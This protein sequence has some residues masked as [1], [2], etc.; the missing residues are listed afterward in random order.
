MA[1]RK[2]GAMDA[3]AKMPWPVG[4][5]AGILAYGAVRYGIGWFLSVAGGPML[6]GLGHTTSTGL[7]APLAWG[8]LVLCWIAAGFSWSLRRR[9]ALLLD[10]QTSIDSLRTMSWRDFETLVAEAFRRRGYVVEETGG[11]GKDGG[12]D[13]ILRSKP[14]RTDL[15]QCKH[16]KTQ[17][18][19]VATVREMWGLVAHH[20]ADGVKIVCVGAFTADAAQFAQGKAI[21][22]IDGVKLLELVREV[23]AG[24]VPV[25]PDK[26]AVPELAQGPTCPR[27]TAVMVRRTSRKN[28]LAF[29]GCSAYPVC[30]GTR[31]L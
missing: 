30:K 8:V 25:M 4:F 6:S 17:R 14:G 15:V 22:L 27:C 29:W 3:L 26:P 5:V 18:V 31:S 20:R 19:N 9:R 10:A 11:G 2:Q 13:L 7:L 1:R 16:W 24:M 12:V 28:T 21:D 23:Q